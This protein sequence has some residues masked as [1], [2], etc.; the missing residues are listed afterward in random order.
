MIGRTLRN[1][2]YVEAQL[3]DGSTAVV[4]RAR[5]MRLERTVA[6]KVL[7][8]HVKDTTRRRF[9]QE[10]RAIAQFS[11]PGIMAIYDADED[12][13]QSFLVVEYVEGETLAH[14]IGAPY[15]TVVRLG[16]QVAD[17]LHYAHARD[18]IHRD[19]KPANVMVTRH[20]QVKIMDLGLALAR[21]AKRVTADGMVIG[22][23]AYL[24]P[25]QAQGLPLDHR[26]DI[27]S[28]GVVLYELLTG[29]LPFTTDD[30]AAL[31]LQHVQ[32]PPPP[33]RSIKPDIPEAVEAAI[34]Q[35]L[36]K[37]PDLRYSTGAMFASALAAALTG[38]S[39]PAPVMRET[40]ESPTPR[41]RAAGGRVL[42]VVLADDH[43]L[44]RSALANYLSTHEDILVVGEA[45]DGA[46][47]VRLVSELNPD[48]LVLDLNMPN[49]GGLD[50]LPTV[51]TRAPDVKVLI[52]TGRTEDWYITQALRRGAHGYL[53]KSNEQSKLVEGIRKVHGGNL[54]LGEGVIEKVVRAMQPDSDPKR[55]SDLERQVVLYLG[56]NMENDAIGRRMGMQLTQVIETI[57]GA[58]NKL[59]VRSREAIP[60]AALRRGDI[61][62]E[63]L[64]AIEGQ[65]A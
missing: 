34:M 43:Q 55:L 65:G 45:S 46:E 5:D 16:A 62:L 48:V 27:Y 42:R 52:L 15:A 64:Q 1:R 47:A 49:L 58:M 54:V 51:R 32:A 30:I 53:L 23:P 39:Q 35:A 33:L 26:T 19:I 14:Y 9:I 25:E 13:G 11:H 29:R 63:E 40:V 7:L 50:V 41:P 8:P 36:E 22:T 61:L 24:S 38:G 17:A 4:Y 44:L 57:A 59:G 28:L 21:D 18:I 37:Q 6:L 3:G 10:A 20:G 12:A 60:M 56:V 2:Y 31:M